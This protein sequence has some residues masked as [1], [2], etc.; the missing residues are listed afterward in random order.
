VL[1][2]SPT[3][4]G[5]I[6]IVDHS[7]AAAVIAGAVVALPVLIAMIRHEDS[8]WQRAAAEPLEPG[9]E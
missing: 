4:M 9:E 3:A 5:A 1:A 2:G 8:A 7:L 6:L